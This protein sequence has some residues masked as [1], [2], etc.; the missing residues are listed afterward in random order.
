[1]KMMRDERNGD[2]YG[3][4]WL[5]AYRGLQEEEQLGDAARARILA[6]MQERAGATAAPRRRI[7]RFPAK[8]WIAPAVAAAFAVTL[9]IF[10]AGLGDG[11]RSRAPAQDAV[12]IQFTA[13]EAEPALHA[14]KDE[15]APADA[16]PDEAPEMKSEAASRL[17][18]E[19]SLRQTRAAGLLPP[20]AA[21]PEEEDILAYA[22]QQLRSDVLEE[23]GLYSRR[24]AAAYDRTE[25]REEIMAEALEEIPL[26]QLLAPL[27]LL[28]A[29]PGVAQV[30][31]GAPAFPDREAPVP[32]PPESIRIE[33]I[34][35]VYGDGEALDP[36]G[37]GIR[38]QHGAAAEAAALDF[39]R[40][41]RL[42]ALLLI[43]TRSLG[44]HEE[45]VIWL[46]VDGEDVSLVL[47]DQP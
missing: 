9:G 47:V 45:L 16:H 35:A 33:A 7:S 34:R 40:D 11:A 2:R 4:V 25:T 43:D 13:G 37:L 14:D 18:P 19:P 5:P 20:E 22:R 29:G 12:T 46:V 27:Q 15:A 28:D 21:L 26:A 6:A 3:E 39:A 1:M 23:E 8:R 44:T 10:W 17:A 31:L 24:E 41:I 30:L 32:D 42:P 38:V 36:A